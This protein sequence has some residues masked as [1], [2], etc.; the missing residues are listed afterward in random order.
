MAKC[1]TPCPNKCKENNE[2]QMILRKDLEKHLTE[3]CMNRDY[4][5]QHRGKKDTFANITGIHDDTCEKKVL[6]CPNADCPDSMQRAK[7]KQHLVND[8]EHTVISCKY[9]G[10]GCDVKMKRKDMGAHEQDDKA[11]LHQALTTV[12]KL[13]EY[14]TKLSIGFFC[15]FVVV[16]W[17]SFLLYNEN[18]KTV[19]DRL[20]SATETLTSMKEAVQD[21]LQSATETITSMKEENKAVQDRLQS[22]TETITSMQKKLKSVLFK[23]INYEKKKKNNEVFSSQSFYTGYNMYIKVHPNGVGDGEGTHVSVFVH[24]LKGDNDDNLKWPFIGTVK[25]ELLN[26]LEDNNHHLMTVPF[27][28]EEDAHVGSAWGYRWFTPHSKLTHDLVNNTQYLKDDTLYF[29]VSVEVSGH[30]PWLECTLK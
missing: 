22:A 1:K 29:R 16:V 25:I 10:I 12:V 23:I 5:C 8:C 15:L 7:I 27:N 18:T 4:K 20:Q 2:I 3:Q 30:K 24:I 6:P 26:Q 21:R 11:H 14:T 28:Q 9:E 17:S 13:K 19:Q